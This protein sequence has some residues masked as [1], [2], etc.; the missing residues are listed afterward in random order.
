MN[1]L[2]QN[3]KMS[4]VNN[5]NKKTLMLN[6]QEYEIVYDNKTQETMEAKQIGM[7]WVKGLKT[8][9]NKAITYPF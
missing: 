9:L 4:I 6:N 8:T 2:I 5:E 3:K 7:P 1:Y